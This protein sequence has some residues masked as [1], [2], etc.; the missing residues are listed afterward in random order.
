M[1]PANPSATSL[2]LE[3]RS[4]DPAGR[5]TR[6]V[7]AGG[8]ETEY[9]WYADNLLHQVNLERPGEDVVAEHYDYSY[10][11]LTKFTS[12]ENRITTF[13]YDAAGNV[14]TQ[15][16]DPSGLNRRTDY[17][18][19]AD[20]T[21][22][23]ATATGA[24]SPGRVETVSYTYDAAG[25]V[26]STTVDN[27]GGSPSSL[28]TTYERDPRGLIV[29]TVDPSGV[30]V[31]QAYDALDRLVTVTEAP[32]S[33]W[34]N[35]TEQTNVSPVTTYGYNTFDELT[36]VE[37]PNGNVT[38]TLYD[39]MG[40]P[41]SVALPEYTPP[42]SSTPIIPVI[43]TSYNDQGLPET[44]TD[45]LG[46][47]TSYTYN[48]YGRV[49]TRT[50]PDPDG[51]TGPKTGPQWSWEYTRTGKVARVTDPVAAYTTYSYDQY[52]D[53]L[54]EECVSEGGHAF[55][56]PTAY[57]YNDAGDV[58]AVITPPTAAAPNGA[59]T[60]I[61]YNKAGEPT[62]ITDP[63]GRLVHIKYDMAGRVVSTA[64]GRNQGGTV[65]GTAPVEATT[66]DLAG[67]A[68]AVSV[69]TPSSSGGCDTVLATTTHT[70]DGA[71]R[72]L[73][74]VTPEGRP[75]FYSYDTA[76][77]LVGVTQRVD[78]SDPGT[79]IT[80]GLGYD[81]AGNLTRMVDG[82]GNATI[83]TYNPWHL[84]EKTI[85][86]STSAHP[87]LPDRTWTTIYDAAGRPIHQLLPGGVVRSATYDNL[88]R[89]IGE[90]GT[91]AEGTTT[92]RTL[93][94]D[95][96]GRITFASSPA[97]NHTFAWSDRG[98]LDTVT[99]YG[100][101]TT[102][103]YDALGALTQRVDAAGTTTFGYD[104]AGRLTSIG[105][106]L[107][108]T[109]ATLTYDDDGRLVSVSR[110]SGYAARTLTYDDFGRVATDTTT[111][112]SGTVTASYTYDDD[113]LLIGK[114]TSGITGAGA[115]TYTYDGLSRITSW[116]SPGGTTTTYGYDNASNRTTVTTPAGTRTATYDARNRLVEITGAGQPDTEFTYNARGQLTA[117]VENG[118][119]KRAYTYDAFERLVG[120][121]GA[122]LP[123]TTYTYDSLDRP[124]QRNSANFGYNDLSN[125][126]VLSPTG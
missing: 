54:V 77:Q 123:T 11:F 93:D 90:T 102:Y 29:R 67:R 126:P 118:Q 33:V 21:V 72:P 50:D 1:D 66:W 38:L 81:A 58:T 28:T 110:G 61:T 18:Y 125:N 25:R 65:T 103:T 92:S 51:P 124:A 44:I 97:G 7:D 24:A 71:G 37:D 43:L 76:G 74:S 27:T 87:N 94:Y 20:N 10:G 62:W 109:T 64:T 41:E 22:A 5:L 112:T 39:E 3:S 88:G 86:P 2:V 120:I 30:A 70:F 8:H 119:T 60:E 47:V 98:L 111:G 55:C 106:P 95:P 52:L 14:S 83:Y 36:H 117:V 63:T 122:S 69:C 31:E 34:V 108:S 121:S 91:G 40:R 23:T 115:N 59:R 100:G 80:V 114:T 45:P 78:P 68:V 32:R 79:A 17:T 53:R 104:E 96:L 46:N 75:T 35:G 13:A 89:L 73:S 26:V 105:D 15:R 42:G 116:L 48:P 84:P 12:A 16:V 56:Y 101:T 57:E 49:L 6:I 107:T 9:Y 4:Y 85:E 82:N 99:G 113:G 19:N